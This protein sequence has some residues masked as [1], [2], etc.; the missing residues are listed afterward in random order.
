MAKQTEETKQDAVQAQSVDL[1][2]NLSMANAA[3]YAG[4]GQ[5]AAEF[6]KEVCEAAGV[7]DP[8]RN[9]LL[10][11]NGIALKGLQ[12]AVA[13]EKNTRRA[14]HTKR[15]KEIQAVFDKAKG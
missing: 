5:T 2:A 3:R 13:D 9:A 7:G 15:L 8:D 14:E 1:P 4:E 6:F 12:L 11:E 10:G